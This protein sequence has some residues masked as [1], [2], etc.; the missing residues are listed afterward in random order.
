MIEVSRT[1]VLKRLSATWPSSWRLPATGTIP[2]GHPLAAMLQVFIEGRAASLPY[3]SSSE[4][5]WCTVA[6]SAEAL[7]AATDS[8][9]AWVLPSFG[10]EDGIRT[11]AQGGELGALLLSLSPAGYL[12]WRSSLTELDRV[13]N[14]LEAMLRLEVRRPVHAFVRAPS[15]LELRLRFVTALV[16][17]EREGAE[18][19][20]RVI[21]RHLLDSAV[22]THFMRIRLWDHFREWERIAAYSAVVELVRVRMP[23]QIRLALVRGF[24]GRHVAPLEGRGDAQGAAKAYIGH[25]HPL[26]SE[27]LVLC[28]PEDGDEVRRCLGYRAWYLQHRQQALQLLQLKSD[29][30]LE[31]L[32]R[33]LVAEAEAPPASPPI[34]AQ[35]QSAVGQQDTRAQQEVG[36]RLVTGLQDE[37]VPAEL[38][39]R[40]AETPDKRANQELSSLLRRV[41]R[42]LS[43]ERLLLAPT[44]WQECGEAMREGNWAAA[45][46]FLDAEARPSAA[47]LPLE[48]F[49]E[50]LDSLEEYFTDPSLDT[51]PRARDVTLSILIATIH[52]LRFDLEFP[53]P[54]HANLF[55]QLLRLFTARKKGSLNREDTA[56]FLLLSNA[57]LEFYPGA[58]GALLEEVG[59]WWAARPG[60]GLLLFLLETLSLVAPHA[61]GNSACMALWTQGAEVLRRQEVALSPGAWRAW[62][63]I[64]HRV[65]VTGELLNVYLPSRESANT[66]VDVLARAGL[67]KIAIVSRQERQAKEAASQIQ[68][69]SGAKVVVVSEHVAGAGTKDAAS[70]DVILLVWSTISHA[71]YRAFDSVR[72]KLTYVP[73]SGAESIVLA[74]E[75]TVDRRET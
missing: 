17:G 75:R 2:Q 72:E 46:V 18:E 26:L 16:A 36:L 47:A 22:N 68:S 54:R 10:W 56:L 71:V 65:G 57:L 66:Q 52:D 37:A 19:V 5:L 39:R 40:L 12:R 48:S 33:P 3:V 53:S 14:K 64:G 61:P 7:R 25:V 9:R 63:S 35:W 20:I 74:L 49:R 60:E 34:E 6:P 29:A 11:S 4:V 45:R 50:L 62:R 23:Q 15:L 58:E 30:L 21:D 13:A 8:I 55:P 32:L 70:A 73:G 44:S 43:G 1:Q 27:L 59:S 31:T 24:H 42:E 28:R 67:R 69:R 38:V 41:A 51:D